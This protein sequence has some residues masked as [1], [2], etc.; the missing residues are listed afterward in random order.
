[1]DIQARVISVQDYVAF[2][3]QP[4]D[5]V[6]GEVILMAAAHTRR[7][8][9]VVTN[10]FRKLDPFVHRHKLGKIFTESSFVLDGD[11]RSKWVRGARTPDLAFISRERIESHNA[12]H[13][14]PDEPWWLAPDLAVEVISPTDRYDY[15]SQKVADYLRFGVKLV[16]V[17]DPTTRTVR[18]HIREEPLG[19]SLSEKEKLTA[20]PMIAGW[21]MKVADLFVEG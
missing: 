15:L 6:D 10:L 19:H 1:M 12:E 17:I 7:Q 14:D 21:S 2:G 5:I 16:W 11:P 20:E 18:V 8:P 4:V 9:N 3:D 13:P